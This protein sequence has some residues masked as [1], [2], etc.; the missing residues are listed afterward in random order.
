M[1]ICTCESRLFPAGSENRKNN[2]FPV[3][4]WQSKVIKRHFAPAKGEMTLSLLVRVKFRKCHEYLQRLAQP[5]RRT[6]GVGVRGYRGCL[7]LYLP[8]SGLPAFSAP[9]TCFPALSTGNDP[10]R[11]ASA[12]TAPLHGHEPRCQRSEFFKSKCLL[13]AE[14]FLL[15]RR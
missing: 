8:T 2:L 3:R 1:K 15:S 11:N 14:V 13:I 12:F 6:R 9:G 7:P 4:K 5:G 10:H